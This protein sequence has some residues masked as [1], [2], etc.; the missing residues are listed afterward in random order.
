MPCCCCCFS[1]AGA[2]LGDRR[3]RPHLLLPRSHQGPPPPPPPPCPACW[4]VLVAARL[5]QEAEYVTCVTGVIWTGPSAAGAQRVDGWLGRADGQRHASLFLGRT[6]RLQ[7]CRLPAPYIVLPQLPYSKVHLFVLPRALSPYIGR[8]SLSPPPT[9]S[10]PPSL[11][12]S[13]HA[14]TYTL[15]LGTTR[16]SPSCR[17]TSTATSSPSS[18]ALPQAPSSPL[19]SDLSPPATH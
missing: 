19:S 14:L 16:R 7:Y 5:L 15:P 9:L 6:A 13:R 3:R 17:H 10:F 4:G 11:L 12:P 18:I 2:R 1:G 8:H